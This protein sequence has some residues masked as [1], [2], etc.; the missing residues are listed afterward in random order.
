M[1]VVVSER[2]RVFHCL[3]AYSSSIHNDSHIGMS[4]SPWL[5]PCTALH[6]WWA[7]IWQNSKLKLLERPWSDMKFIA[8]F[9]H[10][11]RVEQE[12]LQPIATSFSTWIWS[13]VDFTTDWAFL[14][15]TAGVRLQTNA[16]ASEHGIWFFL[17]CH[18]QALYPIN[19]HKVLLITTWKSIQEG[20]ALF[21]AQ[22]ILPFHHD[23]VPLITLLTVHRVSIPESTC[24]IHAD[25]T[26]RVLS[27]NTSY[28]SNT[29][30]NLIGVL[31]RWAHNNL[32]AML[33][34]MCSSQRMRVMVTCRA[35]GR[36][37]TIFL[38]VLVACGLAAI[39]YPPASPLP[40]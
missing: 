3:R 2:L 12:A 22:C 32:E 28:A 39:A 19:F 40:C 1:F 34:S 10:L 25:S 31:I 18:S 4:Y 17:I 21:E 27:L 33:A 14:S 11:P 7:K 38:M 24:F 8:L 20:R 26:A 29:L 30:L 13:H 23:S 16:Q 37:K 15:I 35:S 6:L 5:F 9:S 36:F